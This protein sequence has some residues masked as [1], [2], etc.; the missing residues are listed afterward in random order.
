MYISSN[1]VPTQNPLAMGGVTYKLKYM[2]KPF[3]FINVGRHPYS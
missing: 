3:N 2:L 1:E